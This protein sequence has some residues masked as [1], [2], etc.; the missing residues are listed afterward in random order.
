MPPLDLDLITLI[1]DYV[2]VSTSYIPAVYDRSLVRL[3][4]SGHLRRV[5][6]TVLGT[7]ITLGQI[8]Q[9][10]DLPHYDPCPVHS[11]GSVANVAALTMTRVDLEVEKLT[12]ERMIFKKVGLYKDPYL[13]PH[14][15][16]RRGIPV[17]LIMRLPL[18]TLQDQHG[19]RLADRQNEI[20]A[21]GECPVYASVSGGGL[22]PARVQQL[23]QRHGTLERNSGTLILGVRD[24]EPFRM[25][26]QALNA[27][28]RAVQHRC[29]QSGGLTPA[30]LPVHSHLAPVLR[31]VQLRIPNRIKRLTARAAARP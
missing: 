3:V 7:C 16:D 20:P 29:Q 5:P 12:F 26:D 1:A 30:Q 23:L 28:H 31:A 10:D 22:T 24:P 2:A 9:D 27:P 15:S 8:N 18:R 13:V 11:A 19:H 4:A 17:G 6:N 25:L 14:T 21:L